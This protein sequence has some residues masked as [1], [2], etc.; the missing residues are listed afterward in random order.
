MKRSMKAEGFSCLLCRLGTGVKMEEAK[1]ARIGRYNEELF[2]IAG[3]SKATYYI[4]THFKKKALKCNME[5]VAYCEWELEVP[6]SDVEIVGSSEDPEF[7]EQL[8]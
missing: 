5:P 7:K 8:L 1:L 6:K 2:L 4:T 3:E